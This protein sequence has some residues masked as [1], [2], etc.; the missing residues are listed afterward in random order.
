MLYPC[1][2]HRSSVREKLPRQVGSGV[3]A[4]HHR[5]ASCLTMEMIKA[6]R[7]K[8]RRSRDIDCGISGQSLGCRSQTAAKSDSASLRLSRRSSCPIIEAQFN[9]ALHVI[10]RCPSRGA[11]AEFS[12]SV[13]TLSQSS[14]RSL[15][16]NHL[17]CYCGLTKRTLRQRRQKQSAPHFRDLP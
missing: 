12:W 1:T 10:H 3:G 15:T 8:H 17:A 5:G 11:C 6:I 14:T 2:P 16:D 9:I 4:L 7:H 13:I